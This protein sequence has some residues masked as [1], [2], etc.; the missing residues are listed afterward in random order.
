M[1]NLVIKNGFYTSPGSLKCVT[2]DGLGEYED[3]HPQVQFQASDVEAFGLAPHPDA[4][5]YVVD[6]GELVACKGA[7]SIATLDEDG[8]WM[9]I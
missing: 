3:T 7:N 1:A 4:D 8:G 2:K 5:F 6:Y 9:S